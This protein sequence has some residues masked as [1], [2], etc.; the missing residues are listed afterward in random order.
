MNRSGIKI[1][2]LKIILRLNKNIAD[3]K[4]M[5]IPGIETGNK[6]GAVKIIHDMKIP[7]SPIISR[8]PSNVIPSSGIFVEIS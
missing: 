7:R 1:G 4:G 6:K 3:P 8:N 2:L 5:L